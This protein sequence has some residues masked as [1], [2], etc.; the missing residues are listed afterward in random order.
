M[1][2]QNIPL[3]LDDESLKIAQEWAAQNHL[4]VEGAIILSLVQMANEKVPEG[5]AI[6]LAPASDLL[7]ELADSVE[8]APPSTP[9]EVREL[10]EAIRYFAQF[11]TTRETSFRGLGGKAD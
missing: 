2:M 7:M 11:A 10:A 5:T 3:Q 6:R 8:K 1:A 9:E 4:P